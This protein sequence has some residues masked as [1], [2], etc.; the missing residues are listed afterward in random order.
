MAIPEDAVSIGEDVAEWDS[1]PLVRT[2]QLLDRHLAQQ[3][4]STLCIVLH[5]HI[6]LRSVVQKAKD[7][8]KPALIEDAK[9]VFVNLLDWA[10]N[11][12]STMTRSA[13]CL[14]LVI[15]MQ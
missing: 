4:L 8:E 2:P 7:E 15:D 5:Q 13:E 6:D 3:T 10:D 1:F 12:P 9:A 14:P 11:L